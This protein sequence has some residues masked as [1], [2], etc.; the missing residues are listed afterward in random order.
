MLAWN[1][2]RLRIFV[3]SVCFPLSHM[4]AQKKWDVTSFFCKRLLQHFW[5]VRWGNDIIW[6]H[7][8]SSRIHS[9]LE[10]IDSFLGCCWRKGLDPG[11]WGMQPNN[12][13]LSPKG[14]THVLVGKIM[15]IDFLG[16]NWTPLPYLWQKEIGTQYTAVTIWMTLCAHEWWP[17]C[18]FFVEL[19]AWRV[20]AEVWTVLLVCALSAW[21]GF[22]TIAYSPWLY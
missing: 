9:Q 22:E 21:H 17:I 19:K 2:E 13:K 16:S 5:W 3:C 1:F 11:C 8:A 4:I 7:I 12:Q 10:A 14:F 15:H 6:Y 20:N 18:W